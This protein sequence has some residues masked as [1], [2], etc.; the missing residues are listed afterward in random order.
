MRGMVHNDGLL[1]DLLD[2]MGGVSGCVM[3]AVRTWD[4]QHVHNVDG[5]FDY[6]FFC[7]IH[8]PSANLSIQHSDPA[9][10]RVQLQPE[11]Q[12]YG[13]DLV[14]FVATSVEIV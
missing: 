11:P 7:G 9:L 14:P 3:A 13:L 1:L 10:G 8:D 2:P 12:H 6:D 4:E 5:S